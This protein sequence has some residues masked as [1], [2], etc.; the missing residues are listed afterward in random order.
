MDWDRGDDAGVLYTVA[1]CL[2]RCAARVLSGP[3]ASCVPP[4]GAA[5]YM[6]ICM[7]R[8]DEGGVLL[9][10]PQQP[11]CLGAAGLV[12]MMSLRM[13]VEGFAGWVP[14]MPFILDL[15]VPMILVW[16]PAKGPYGP[17][18]KSRTLR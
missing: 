2:L 13:L 16:N 6:G 4:P 18:L 14:R 1:V 12:T 9:L 11:V 8:G 17:Y 15:I 5:V 10:L 3:V 7:D